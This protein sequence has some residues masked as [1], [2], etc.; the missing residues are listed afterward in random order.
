M[1]ASRSGRQ[2]PG[3]GSSLSQKFMS[4]TSGSHNPS[5]AESA[6]TALT[7]WLRLRNSSSLG[8]KQYP[9][10]PPPPPKVVSPEKASSA[11]SSMR[12]RQVWVVSTCS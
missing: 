10:P 5:P 4:N 2:P 7:A 1:V 8:R 9:L 12:R 3:A 11:W 6:T